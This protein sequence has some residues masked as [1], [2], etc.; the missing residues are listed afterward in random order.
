MVRERSSE[1]AE[2]SQRPCT[3]K[4]VGLFKELVSR[5][6]GTRVLAGP[7]GGLLQRLW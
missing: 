4:K 6:R 5:R 1:E 2:A 7:H 3:V